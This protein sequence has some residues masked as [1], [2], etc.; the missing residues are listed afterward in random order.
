MSDII[1]TPAS[2]ASPVDS[3]VEADGWFPAVDCNKLRDEIRLG[4]NIV[5]HKRLVAAI[6]GAMV[7]AFRQ[8]VDWRAE[9]AGAGAATLADVPDT[10]T[11]AGEEVP[12]TINGEPRAVILW[13]RIVRYYA[14]AELAD[15]YRDLI[16]TDQQSQRSDERRI[17]ADDY[18]RMAHNAV[19]DL[20]SIGAAE[21][22][23]RNSVEL[24]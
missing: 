8:L 7:H 1:S 16:A 21:S 5:Q 6:E 4:E 12:V 3:K 22:V 23:A 2:P 20:M 19:A 14:A 15:G 11:I 9:R 10:M 24:I 18:R 13:D 17:S